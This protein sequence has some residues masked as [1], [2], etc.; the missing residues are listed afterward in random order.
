MVT[1]NAAVPH[2]STFWPVSSL[3]LDDDIDVDSS[4]SSD[5]SPLANVAAWH[6]SF[7]KWVPSGYAG[8]LKSPG[9][10]WFPCLPHRRSI[11]YTYK[12]RLTQSLKSPDSIDY[13]THNIQTSKSLFLAFETLCD[14]L[15]TYFSRHFYFS[16]LQKRIHSPNELSC[17]FLNIF[18]TLPTS[19]Y[20]NNS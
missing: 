8:P 9:P 2:S 3:L 16:M 10:T 4:Q 14:L 17:Y 5:P 13:L 20:K 19:S 12:S 18:S 6:I 15:S 11:S 1:L 7:C